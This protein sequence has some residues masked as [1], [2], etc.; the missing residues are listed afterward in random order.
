[1][2]RTTKLKNGEGSFEIPVDGGVNAEFFRQPGI[3]ADLN[4]KSEGVKHDDEV[5]N[6]EKAGDG[7]SAPENHQG[8]VGTICGVARHD[9]FSF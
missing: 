2:L 7:Q 9:G 5:D 6:G 4:P 1:M 3:D 8:H